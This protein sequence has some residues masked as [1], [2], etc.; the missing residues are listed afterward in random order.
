MLQE[1]QQQQHILDF[2]GLTKAQHN[3]R[4]LR[5]P[6]LVGPA[7]KQAFS[8]IKHKVWQRLQGWKEKFISQGGKEILIKIVAME[9]RNYT[10]SCFKLL[11]SLCKEIEH[12]MPRFWWGQQKEEWRIHWVS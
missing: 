12:M 8:K 11:R 2:L 5:L 6:S 7:K 10:M 9:I 3:N 1:Q 4:Y